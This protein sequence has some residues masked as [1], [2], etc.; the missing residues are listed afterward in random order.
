M[1]IRVPQSSFIALL[2]QIGCINSGVKDGSKDNELVREIWHYLIAMSKLTAKDTQ[3]AAVNV[4]DTKLFLMAIL[5]IKGN[6]RMGLEKTEEEASELQL[7]KSE[8]AYGWINK[9]MQLCLTE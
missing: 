8:F 9:Q 6:K 4:G 3:E 1:P 2:R 7:D 5:G